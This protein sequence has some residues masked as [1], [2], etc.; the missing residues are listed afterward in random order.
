MYGLNDSV[1]TTLGSKISHL[2]SIFLP[3]FERTPLKFYN[4]VILYFPDISKDPC[5][6]QDVISS[7][8]KA[9]YHFEVMPICEISFLKRAKIPLIQRN[10]V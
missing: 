10:V 2:V 8:N 6:K 1:Q 3:S 9:L 5:A 4:S 7:V